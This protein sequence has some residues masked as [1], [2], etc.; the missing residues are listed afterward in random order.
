V[1]IGTT[2]PVEKLDVDGNIKATLFLENNPSAVTNHGGTPTY[3]YDEIGATSQLGDDD[4]D[5]TTIAPSDCPAG[6]I[7][8]PGNKR[9]GTEGGFCVMKYEAKYVGGVATSQTSGTPWVSI[10]QTDAIAECKALVSF[11]Y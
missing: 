2:S 3:C 11:N 8:V 5:C 9:Y 6:F 1:G 10:T 7:S 4:S